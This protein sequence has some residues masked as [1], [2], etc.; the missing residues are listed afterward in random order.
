MVEEEEEDGT[1]L[2]VKSLARGVSILRRRLS[3]EVF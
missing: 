3:V 2:A 1:F